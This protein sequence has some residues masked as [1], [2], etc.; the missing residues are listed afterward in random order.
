MSHA[1]LASEQKDPEADTELGGLHPWAP[2]PLA[3]SSVEVGLGG[4]GSELRSAWLVQRMVTL[5]QH[6]RPI[7][8]L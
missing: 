2:S 7:P 4:V 3:G 1:R 8:V 5:E 6:L